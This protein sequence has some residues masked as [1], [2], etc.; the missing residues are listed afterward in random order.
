MPS[1]TKFRKLESSEKRSARRIAFM[2]KDPIGFCSVSAS[3]IRLGSSNKA[4]LT[5]ARTYLPE[6]NIKV[7]YLEN[8]ESSI[9]QKKGLMD[10]NGN[11]AK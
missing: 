8:P 1:I 10:P 9:G 6:K 7:L 3:S 11:V 2:C 5:K 4:L